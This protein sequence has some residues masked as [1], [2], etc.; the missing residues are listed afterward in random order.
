MAGSILVAVILLSLTFW[1]IIDSSKEEIIVEKE[2]PTY[3][4]EDF[5]EFQK[6]LDERKE[7]ENT[8]GHTDRYNWT[9]SES[10]VDIYIPIEEFTHGL[11]SGSDIKIDIKSTYVTAYIGKEKIL[12]DS[13]YEAVI[14]SECNWQIEDTDTGTRVLW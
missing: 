8:K 10:E 12:D 13:F 5:S 4:K 9:Q 11:I 14:P 6:L 7:K 2:T 1:H 3:D